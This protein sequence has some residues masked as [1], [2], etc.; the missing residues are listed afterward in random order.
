LSTAVTTSPARRPMAWHAWLVTRAFRG[1]P[2]SRLARTIGPG[3]SPVVAALGYALYPQHQEAVI[4]LGG[5]SD[6]LATVF[7]LGGSTRSSG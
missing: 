2:Q 7:I 5:S 1:K 6:V 3:V 4:W